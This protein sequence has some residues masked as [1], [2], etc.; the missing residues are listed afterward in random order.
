MSG[1]VMEG[2]LYALG[3][4]NALDLIQKLS[5]EGLAW[6]PQPLNLPQAGWCI[7]CFKLTDTEV[8]FVLDKTLYSL[9]TLRPVKTLAEGAQSG[10]GPSHYS[11]GILYCSTSG[12]AASRLKIGSLN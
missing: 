12:G 7:P 9:Q 8:Y 3:G 6:E 4:T 5:L 2:S 10:F 11:R 1:V